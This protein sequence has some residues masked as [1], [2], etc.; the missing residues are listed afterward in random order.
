MDPIWLIRMTR[1]ARHPPSRNRIILVGSV[2]LACLAIWGLEQVFG[3]PW[4]K[5]QVRPPSR[6]R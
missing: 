4:D 6:L 1:W 2:V 5:E 3:F